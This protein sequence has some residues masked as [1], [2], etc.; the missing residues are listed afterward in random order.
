MNSRLPYLPAQAVVTYPSRV[1]TTGERCTAAELE[2]S[3]RVSSKGV[4][5]RY[6]GIHDN[7]ACDTDKDFWAK[8]VIGLNL[9][10]ST[11]SFVRD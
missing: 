5:A 2:S 8:R 11:I 1:T 10:Y 7:T 3:G 4:P 6:R 9:L